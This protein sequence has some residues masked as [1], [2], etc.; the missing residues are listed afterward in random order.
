MVRFEL[1]DLKDDLTG[2][3]AMAGMMIEAHNYL[4]PMKQFTFMTSLLW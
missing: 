3:A 2:Y 4:L 1:V